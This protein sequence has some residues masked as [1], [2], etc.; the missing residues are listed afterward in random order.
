MQVL[1][2]LRSGHNQLGK[3]VQR[4]AEAE[5]A[6]QN[7]GE[8]KG[9][10]A[11]ELLFVE[12][13]LHPGPAREG[14]AVFRGHAGEMRAALHPENAVDHVLRIGRLTDVVQAQDLLKRLRPFLHQR[15]IVQRKMR[16]Q[17]PQSAF[18]RGRPNRTGRLAKRH[19]ALDRR[20]ALQFEIAVLIAKGKTRQAGRGWCR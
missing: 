17:A 15:K 3:A 11:H 8:Q 7:T 12:L 14:N 10:A 20:S 1:L 4:S 16:D 18:A 6:L 2:S 13:H 5:E 9:A 19:D